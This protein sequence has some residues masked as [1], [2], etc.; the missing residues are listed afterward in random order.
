MPLMVEEPGILKGI[1]W[2]AFSIFGTKKVIVL[3]GFEII[4]IQIAKVDAIL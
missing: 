3:G 2:M 1:G 4:R